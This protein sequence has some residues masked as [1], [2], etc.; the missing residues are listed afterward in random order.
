MNRARTDTAGNE[1]PPEIIKADVYM[2][3][4]P[5]LELP[6][7]NGL[8]EFGRAH[9]RW[10]F[11]LR[12]RG[13]K[14]TGAVI[15]SAS[16]DGVLIVVD[17][18][19]AEEALSFAGIP[20]ARLMPPEMKRAEDV[21]VDDEAIG[22]TGAD[23]FLS[24]GF[25]KCAFCGVGTS[26]SSVRR[27]GFE[28]RLAEAGT[29]CVCA[30]IPFDSE[31]DWLLCPDAEARIS[32][33]ISGLE[34]GYAVMAAHDALANRIVDV[35]V[36]EGIRVPN[37]IAVLGTGNHR[38]LC[39]I[40]PVP[41]SSV[42]TNVPL[43]AARGAA[44]LHEMLRGK[45]TGAGGVLVQPAGVVE[46]ESTEITV[47]GD[48]IV[49]E[50]CRYVREEATSF[51]SAADVAGRFPMSRRTLDRRFR[52]Y[53][54]RSISEEIRSARLSRALEMVRSGTVSLSDTAATC[55]FSDLS[56]MCRAFMRAFGETPGSMRGHSLR[57]T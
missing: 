19:G 33:F 20:F 49:A 11:S 44:M 9:P 35:C 4:A 46:R 47:Y 30:D 5:L 48:A 3:A 25:M 7:V 40:S 17:G 36:R 42:D 12:Q 28:A 41:L 32:G 34:S 24:R 22:R 18:C 29:K 31:S 45:Y 8:L 1:A 51:V 16:V 43:V 39:E 6:L 21:G 57:G 50:V 52:K 55:G 37:D 2:G 10:R 14:Y 23:F 13:F 26:W 56:H 53:A 54:G 15:S 38:L 27:G